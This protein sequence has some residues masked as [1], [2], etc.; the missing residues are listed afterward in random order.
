MKLLNSFVSPFAGRVRL[1]IYAHN[2]PVEIVPSGQWTEDFRKSPN[3]LAINP[4]GRVPTLVLDDG[5]ALPE[6]AVIV[7]YLADAFPDS[8]LRPAGAEAAAR[9]RLLAH[10]TEIYVQEQ[11]TRLFPQLF[12]AERDLESIRRTVAAMDTGLSYLD[13]FMGDLSSTGERII[14]TADCA[15]VVY[16]FFFAD[17]MVRALD[18]PAIIKKYPRVAAY[19]T[20]MQCVPAARQVLDEMRTAIAG[21]RLN[22]LVS[23][24]VELLGKGTARL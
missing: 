10:L 13:H 6:S 20:A 19:W 18:Q 14:R 8:A 12:T 7:E 5:S 16:L 9:D 11:A 4:I 22:M 21:S 17:L 1:A 2:L 23:P 24:S 3:Y 15:L